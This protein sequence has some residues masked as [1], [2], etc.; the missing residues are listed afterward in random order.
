MTKEVVLRAGNLKRDKE[1]IVERV[2][3]SIFYRRNL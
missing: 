3:I 1:S 2:I